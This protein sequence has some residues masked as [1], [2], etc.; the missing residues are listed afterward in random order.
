MLLQIGLMGCS[1]KAQI[2]PDK[3]VIACPAPVRPH[4]ELT[5]A[6][7]NRDR[8]IEILQLNLNATIDYALKLEGALKC[9]QESVK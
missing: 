1:P 8:I 2:P 3:P 4:L 7:A 9:W 6:N 5:E